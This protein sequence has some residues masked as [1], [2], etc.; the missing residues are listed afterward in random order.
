MFG[1]RV[2]WSGGAALSGKVTSTAGG[3]DSGI[4][5]AVFEAFSLQLFTRIYNASERISQ[6]TWYRINWYH[7]VLSGVTS[8]FLICKSPPI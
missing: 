8:G 3:L 7:D 1:E 4:T 6:G 5:S 2:E